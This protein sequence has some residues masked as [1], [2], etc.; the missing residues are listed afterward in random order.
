VPLKEC[1]LQILEQSPASLE[2]FFVFRLR[3][4]DFARARHQ[5]GFVLGSVLVSVLFEEFF[6]ESAKL[7]LR[8]MVDGRFLWPVVIYL[9]VQLRKVDLQ[10]AAA[11]TL[12]RPKVGLQA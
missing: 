11:L 12:R 9:R 3:Q 10:L 5:L 4:Q 6:E 2:K 1:F 8:Q 7:Y